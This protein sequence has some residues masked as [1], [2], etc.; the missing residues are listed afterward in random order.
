MTPPVEDDVP[1]IGMRGF[2]A[3][4]R[5]PREAPGWTQTETAARVS[6]ATSAVSAGWIRLPAANTS[7]VP[8]SS[9]VSTAG[10]RVAG[11]AVLRRAGP[12]SRSGIRS[13]MKTSSSQRTNRVAPDRVSVRW[14]D[15]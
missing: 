15:Q 7:G 11:Q 1:T 10:P 5:A 6:A 13:P 12:S 4:L 8:V 9:A 14:C 3:E 2:A